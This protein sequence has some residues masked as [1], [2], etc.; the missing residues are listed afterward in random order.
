[1]CIS[2]YRTVST[3]VVCVLAGIPPIELVTDERKRIYSTT[4]RISPGSGKVL[5]VK[6]DEGR[7]LVVNEKKS[8]LEAQ[9]ESVLI[10]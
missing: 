1:M 10:C 5:W 9:K 3:E 2:T 4:H 6:C 8:S 7:S